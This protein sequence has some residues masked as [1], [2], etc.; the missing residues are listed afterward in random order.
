MEEQNTTNP[1]E[2][3]ESK[4][5]KP[6]QSQ[7]HEKAT[8]SDTVKDYKAEFRKII[9]PNR[10]EMTKKTITVIFTS[11]LVGVVIFCMDTVYTAGY[12]FILSLL[13]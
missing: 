8:F 10:E 2:K 12:N 13:G 11:L 7:N 5:K 3:D 4:Q 9:W 1:N 6:K